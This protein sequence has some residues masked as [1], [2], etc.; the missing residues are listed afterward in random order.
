M[1][2]H[3]A[4]SGHLRRSLR[5]RD[6]GGCLRANCEIILVGADLNNEVSK[7]GDLFVSEQVNRNVC[8]LLR[9]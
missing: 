3:G 1:S 4:D 5:L 6:G 7:G 2:Y 9:A 8:L